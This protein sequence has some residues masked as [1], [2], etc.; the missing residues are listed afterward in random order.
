[1]IYTKE[2]EHMCP[3]GRMDAAHGPSPIPQEI[4]RA[5]V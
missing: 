3:I 1:M 4:G 2:V 5:H